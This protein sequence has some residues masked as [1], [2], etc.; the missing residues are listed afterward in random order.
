MNERATDAAATHIGFL[1]PGYSAEDDYPLADELL[2]PAVRLSL[3]HTVIESDAHRVEELRRWGDDV[4]LAVAARELPADLD[5]VVWAC[6]SGSFVFG[7][8]GAHRQAE[9]LSAAVG[10]PASSTSL[11]FAHA[12]NALGVRTVAVAGTY[13]DDVVGLF[14]DFLRDAG[15]EVARRSSEGILLASDVGTLD[16]DGVTELAIGGDHDD[17]EAILLPDTALHSVAWLSDIE[18]RLGK[19]VL[20]AN[21]V[22]VWEGLR[23]A[24]HDAPRAPMGELFAEVPAGGR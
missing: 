12:A 13:P 15:I 7:W 10:V 14:V 5:A 11:A 24:G 1:Y 6:T 22:S 17:A 20:T 3:V 23:L 21:Q 9:A 19:P 8:Q 2:G 18:S 16:H 4:A